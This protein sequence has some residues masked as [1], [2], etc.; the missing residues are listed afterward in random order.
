MK[1]SQILYLASNSK[2]RQ[3]ALKDMKI[4]FQVIL[5][6]SPEFCD[7]N[8]EFKKIAESIAVNK[9]DNI[10]LPENL[11]PN[12]KLIKQG[13]QI[14]VLTADT[15]TRDSSGKIHGKPQNKQD[16][17][18]KIKQVS[19][20]SETCTAF[21]LDIKIFDGSKWVTQTRHLQSVSSLC[22]FEISPDLYEKYISN[23]DALNCCGALDITGYGA[24]F[25]KSVTGSYS[26]ILGLPI[27]E[28]RM[29]LEKLKFF[30]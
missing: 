22:D 26:A 2:Y 30:K 1:N 25:L 23:T 19:G 28:V 6:T 3:Q 11:L 17:I 21:C 13:D 12:S 5:Q 14:F 4:N 15:M 16:C 29:A 8:L 9:M 10:I 7:Y 24:Q 18:E 27:L 20:F